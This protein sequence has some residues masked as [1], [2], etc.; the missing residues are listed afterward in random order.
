[1]LFLSWARN[2]TLIG[3][4][5][6]HRVQSLYDDDAEKATDTADR[7]TYFRSV[8][9]HLFFTRFMTR[10]FETDWALSQWHKKIWKKNLQR[11]EVENF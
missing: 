3:T 2:R 9:D 8:I 6:S 5:L 7:M 4:T 11:R 1:M 10:D